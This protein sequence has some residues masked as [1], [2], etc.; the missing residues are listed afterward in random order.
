MHLDAGIES[1]I[2]LMRSLLFSNIPNNIHPF[3]SLPSHPLNTLYR[4]L[5]AFPD[6]HDAIT[7]L[8]FMFALNC[9]KIGLI[10]FVHGLIKFVNLPILV[11]SCNLLSLHP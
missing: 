11:L 10:K 8:L 1:C 3:S 4:P 6:G 7:A 5:I 9:N 2:N